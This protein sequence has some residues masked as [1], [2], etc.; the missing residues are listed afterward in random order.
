MYKFYIFN[1]IKLNSCYIFLDNRLI[2]NCVNIA[3]IQR[4]YKTS[5][6]KTFSTISD[7]MKSQYFTKLIAVIPLKIEQSKMIFFTTVKKQIQI[8]VYCILP[9]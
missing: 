7:F 4:I 8:Q 3:Y 5:F 9:Q 1:I 6:L 2:I